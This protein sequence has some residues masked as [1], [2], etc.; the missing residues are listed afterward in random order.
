M[1][2]DAIEVA[3]LLRRVARGRHGHEHLSPE[4]AEAAF[5]ALLQADAD[6]LQ[7]GAFLIAQRMKGETTGET[8]GFV[9]AA[10]HRVAGFGDAAAPAGC[11]D[12]PCYAGKRRAAPV[13][14]AAALKVR[15]A[16]IPVFVHGVAQIEGR[17]SAWQAL[18]AAGVQRVESLAAAQSV[19]QREGI[20]YADLAELCPPL[21]RVYGLRPRLGVRSFANT[22]ARL[23]N[24]L[25][26]VGQLNGFFHTPYADRMAGANAQLG[27]PRSLIFMGA[28]GEPELY[29]ERQKVVAM[30]VG[31]GIRMLDLPDSGCDPYP[32]QRSG[33]DAIAG[34]FAAIL[35]GE[36]DAREAA[37][38]SRMLAAFRWAAG[39][40]SPP[41][42]TIKE[43]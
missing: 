31:D 5:A 16:G 2:M 13:H 30:Q 12:L 17:V 4:E 37:T 7:L 29:A 26:C 43:A 15:D 1:P 28:E 41:E 18:A 3:A 34:R 11:V 36:M 32:K 21:F 38:F 8:A 6:P 39:G 9:R 27:Q 33:P 20:V 14:L 24:P 10:R 40:E 19:L 23:L 25:A 22:V 42:W 35:K